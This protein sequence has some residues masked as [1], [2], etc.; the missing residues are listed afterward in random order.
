M[1]GLSRASP[2][3]PSRPRAAARPGSTLHLQ[4]MKQPTC[5]LHRRHLLSAPRND[6]GGGRQQNAGLRAS[7]AARKQAPVQQ[8]SHLCWIENLNKNTLATAC[9][10]PLPLATSQP[11]RAQVRQ[12]VCPKSRSAETLQW[13]CRLRKQTI[14]ASRLLSDMST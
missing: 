13:I 12:Q 8:L 14:N 6:S 10:Q 4:D 11:S 1:P 9:R 2:C 3:C 5:L 7:G